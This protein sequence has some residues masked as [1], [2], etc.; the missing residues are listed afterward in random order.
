MCLVV[1][2]ILGVISFNAFMAGSYTLGILCASASV[3]F[4]IFMF[5]NIK[6]MREYKRDKKS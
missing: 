2:V 3:A 4:L 6:K 5:Y 1:A